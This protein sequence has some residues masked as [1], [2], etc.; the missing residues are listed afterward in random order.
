YETAIREVLEETG[1]NITILDGFRH[2]NTYK[3][4]KNITK[5]VAYF[6]ATSTTTATV[7]QPEEIKTALFMPLSKARTTLTYTADKQML[8][9]AVKFYENLQK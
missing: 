8:E 6:V 3:P 4:A 2:E 7:P 1:V 9:E 5:T